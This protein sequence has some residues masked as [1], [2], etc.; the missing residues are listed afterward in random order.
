MGELKEQPAVNT[1][2]S[3]FV[4]ISTP[5]H[6]CVELWPH[7]TDT[8]L[9]MPV[10]IRKSPCILFTS[11]WLNLSPFPGV[12]FLF[13][14]VLHVLIFGWVL[15]IIKFFRNLYFVIY[16][17]LFSFG[18]FQSFLEASISFFLLASMA[19]HFLSTKLSQT[20]TLFPSI[21]SCQ[22]ASSSAV[23]LTP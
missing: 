6:C 21:W 23:S 14:L 16:L 12:I 9:N 4:Y 22:K 8:V 3:F 1:E 11:F 10:A 20:P 13:L 15:I 18:L 2:I 19:S 17:N 7:M 5:V